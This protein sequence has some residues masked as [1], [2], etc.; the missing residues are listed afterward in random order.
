[1]SS[2]A[3][4]GP[5]DDAIRA[6]TGAG[7]YDP[8]DARAGDR[9]ALLTWLDERGITLEQMIDA[10]ANGNLTSVAGDSLLR[11][12]PLWTLA[13]MAE[14]L[15]TS[16]ELLDELRR[17]GGFPPV[18]PLQRLFTDIDLLQ[19]RAFMDA[20]AFFSRNELLHL[21]RVIGSSL[22]R[23]ADA[24]GEMFFLDV[25]A[26]LRTGAGTP[27]DLAKKNLEAMQLLQGAIAVFEPMFRAQL[28]E[29]LQASRAARRNSSDLETVPLAIGFVDLSGYTSMAEQIS[30]DRLLR[31]VLD[32]EASAYDLVAECGGRVVKLIGDEVMFTT[33]DAPSACDIALGLL[34]EVGNVDG[35]RPRGGVAFGNVIAHGGDIYGVS[36]NRASRMADIAVPDE[37]LV[38]SEVVARAGGR[39]F[40]PAGR[41][42]LKGFREPVALWSLGREGSSE[43]APGT[44]HA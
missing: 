32:F 3:T 2:G 30:P 33:I 42:Q 25:E 17:A 43:S 5:S 19:F 36:V 31:A 34:D 40:E 13:D 4:T 12:N 22:R 7:L 6:W 28:Q 9:L 44:A 1:V 15:G 27:L 39:W 8:A 21:T 20:S 35:A 16:A 41:R 23:I 37:I 18:D 38:D 11:E 24:S 29:S 14:Q 10:N 26:P